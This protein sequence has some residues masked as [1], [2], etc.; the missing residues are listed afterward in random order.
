MCES[1]VLR[2]KEAKNAQAIKTLQQKLAE[3]E[4]EKNNLEAE[5]ATQLE[6]NATQ[7]PISKLLFFLSAL[8]CWLLAQTPD[9]LA[10]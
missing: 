7:V 3:A 4:E 9:A 5:L 8:E 2:E 1:Q 10:D 6:T